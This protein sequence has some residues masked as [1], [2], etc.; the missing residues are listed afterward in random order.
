LQEV[1]MNLIMNGIDEMKDV[2]GTRE[3]AIKSQRGENEQLLVSI[4]DTGVG[5]SPQEADQSAFKQISLFS[6]GEA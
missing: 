3:L 4:N 2:D 6:G 5:L 1:L